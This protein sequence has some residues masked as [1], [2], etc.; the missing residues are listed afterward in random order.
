MRAIAAP[1]SG[2]VQRGQRIVGR[3]T[4]TAIT[5]FGQEACSADGCRAWQAREDVLVG[6]PGKCRSYSEWI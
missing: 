6:V 3:E 2:P 5:D 1:V 4:L